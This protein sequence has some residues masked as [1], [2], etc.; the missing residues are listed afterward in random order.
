MHS[1]DGPSA[2]FPQDEASMLSQPSFVLEELQ[3]RESLND[4]YVDDNDLGYHQSDFAEDQLMTGCAKLTQKYGYPE[5]AVK[6][7]VR[8]ALQKK[9][10]RKFDNEVTF[11][12]GED[13]IYPL[14]YNGIIY[15]VL[16]IKVIYDRER[17]GY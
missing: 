2:I 7:G 4:E 9:P 14:E 3:K 15:D 13:A 8:P 10:T 17:T 5:S 6:K 11:P 12:S 16:K 1:E